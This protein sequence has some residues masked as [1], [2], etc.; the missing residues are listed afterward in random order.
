MFMTT[1]RVD[2]I[3]MAFQSRIHLTLG[4]KSLDA[5]ARLGLWRLFLERTACYEAEAWPDDVLRRLAEVKLNGR[6]IKNAV[7]TANSLA[8]SEKHLLSVVD[9]DVV[10][11]TIA[12][13]D[14]VFEPESGGL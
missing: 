12:E 6:Q 14:G 1:N 2:T 9:I 10:L 8:L 5:K 13:A 4:Y 11:D 3:D 7:R